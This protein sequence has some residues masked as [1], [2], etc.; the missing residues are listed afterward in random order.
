[1]AS[2]AA[3]PCQGD[4]SE[5]YLITGTLDDW[6]TADVF[7]EFISEV[8]LVDLPFGCILDC[9]LNLSILVSERSRITIRFCS[10]GTYW[11]MGLTLPGLF[12]PGS[13][14]K[15]LMMHSNPLGYSKMF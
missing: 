5:F 4:S 2:A 6:S 11:S 10:E 7:D 14:W 3:K 1:M 13:I 12:I 9:L 15:D 8:G